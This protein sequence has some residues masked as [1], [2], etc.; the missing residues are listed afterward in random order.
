[1]VAQPLWFM[2]DSLTH[3]TEEHLFYRG[4]ISM[5]GQELKNAG[6]A[7]VEMNNGEFV[8]VMRKYAV[9]QAKRS[10]KVDADWIRKEAGKRGFYPN[11]PNA[12]GA[13]FRTAEHNP[14]GRAMLES[15]S[16]AYPGSYIISRPTKE[17]SLQAI[18][19]KDVTE[20]SAVCLGKDNGTPIVWMEVKGKQ[21]TVHRCRD[22]HGARQMYQ[23]FIDVLTS[24]GVIA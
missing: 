20:N 15:L 12:Y 24:A 16:R 3:H 18:G 13:I 7:L 9:A 5:N 23:D 22:M 11:H 10:G 14:S 6:I 8:Q 2:P 4:A 21:R 17:S 19:R 1:M